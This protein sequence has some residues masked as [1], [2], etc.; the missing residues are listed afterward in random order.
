[1]IKLRE[2]SM[3]CLS[4]KFRKIVHSGRKI[5]KLKWKV[6][7]EIELEKKKL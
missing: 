1:M 6:I 2:T 5:G 4:C 7:K 3:C